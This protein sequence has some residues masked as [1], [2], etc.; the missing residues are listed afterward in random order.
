MLLGLFVILSALP[1]IPA[2]IVQVGPIVTEVSPINATRIAVG[3]VI[4]VL[5]LITY[6]GKEALRI[7]K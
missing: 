3:S 6:F 2:S 5:G 1:L 7:L 4:F